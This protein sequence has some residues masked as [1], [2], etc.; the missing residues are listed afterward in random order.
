VVS[1]LSTGPRVYL[2]SYQL[3]LAELR[4]GQVAHSFFAPCSRRFFT[5]ELNVILADIYTEVGP[6]PTLMGIEIL[7]ICAAGAPGFTRTSSPLLT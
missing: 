1:I 7:T 6:A 2:V 3:K 5:D 4:C